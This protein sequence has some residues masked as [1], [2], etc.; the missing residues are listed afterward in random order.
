MMCIHAAENLSTRT[1]TQKAPV[2]EDCHQ[3]LS[4]QLETSFYVINKLRKE[5][6]EESADQLAEII[7]EHIIDR[8]PPSVHDRAVEIQ[9][10][11][12]SL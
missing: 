7:Q 11:R 8:S 9:R 2:D 12:G 6:D 10:E 3:V 5:G 4:E 1:L